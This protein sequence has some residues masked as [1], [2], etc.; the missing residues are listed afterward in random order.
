MFV[1]C[2][3]ATTV[4]EQHIYGADKYGWPQVF[5]M[6]TY[7]E[8]KIKTQNFDLLNLCMDFSIWLALNASIMILIRLMKV[9]RT[10]AE[11]NS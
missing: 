8:G 5:Y 7:D 2:I 6:I 11:S 9:D 1:L 4:K 3:S 10:K